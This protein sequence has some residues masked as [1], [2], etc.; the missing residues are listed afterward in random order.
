MNKITSKK[1]V[2]PCLFVNELPLYDKQALDNACWNAVEE[3]EF[4][5]AE[6]SRI[7]ARLACAVRAGASD[8]SLATMIRKAVAK[9]EKANM[10]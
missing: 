6:S 3:R 8:T 9:R 5:H 10:G 7:Y 4:I 1:P 2:E